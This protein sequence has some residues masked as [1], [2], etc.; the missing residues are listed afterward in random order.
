MSKVKGPG[1]SIDKAAG[2]AQKR[3]FLKKLVKIH[4]AN[5]KTDRVTVPLMKT[6]EMLLTA[7]YLSEAEIQEDIHEI[8]SLAVSECNKSKNITKLI[9][10]IGVFAGLVNSV[11]AELCKKGIKTLLFL[12]YHNFP[13]VRSMAAEKLYT[14]VLT[15]E[16]Y[17]AVI[18]GGEDAYEAVQAL[19]SET[20][21]SHDA[22]TLAAQTKVEMYG[23]FGYETQLKP[24]EEVKRKELEAKK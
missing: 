20:D 7:D 9:A 6:I 17:E 1:D 3:N 13:K 18:P 4:T 10:G 22:K 8:H 5:L 15:M 23:F 11:D 16:E 24:A 12:L 19:L 14:G 2:I 21:W